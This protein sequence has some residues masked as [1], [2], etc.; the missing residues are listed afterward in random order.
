MSGNEKETIHKDPRLLKQ[1]EF[2]QL[3]DQATQRFTPQFMDAYGEATEGY[4]KVGGLIDDAHADG[5]GRQKYATGFQSGIDYL[6][7]TD[8]RQLDAFRR[9]KQNVIN[10]ATTGVNST[11]AGAGMGGSS[12][13]QN[14]LAEA[15]SNGSAS[16]ENDAF[17]SFL[18]RMLPALQ[19]SQGALVNNNAT[20]IALDQAH[21]ANTGGLVGQKL[22]QAELF[23][24]IFDDNFNQLSNGSQ[25]LATTTRKTKTNP[26][27]AE[28]AGAGADLVGA[29]YKP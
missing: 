5:T 10:D 26:G 9:L 20:D 23:Q 22:S 17:Q 18:S 28:I 7:G 3:S 19:A 15:I 21:I 4:N 8:G 24:Q 2:N 12:L 13:N 6:T 14:A 16:V 11:F 29:L 25:N 1:E 27:I